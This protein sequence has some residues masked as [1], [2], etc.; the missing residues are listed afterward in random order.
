MAKRKRTRK[1]KIEKPN[2]LPVSFSR[3]NEDHARMVEL[4]SHYQKVCDEID[5]HIAAAS[6]LVSKIDPLQLLDRAYKENAAIAVG[7]AIEAELGEEDMIA[8]RMIDYVQCLIVSTPPNLENYCDLTN[9]HWEKLKTHVTAI[10]YQLVSYFIVASAKRETE[11]EVDIAWEILFTKAQMNWCYIKGDRYI[12]HFY[13]H[14]LSLFQPHDDVLEELFNISA[15]ELVNELEKI[16]VSLTEGMFDAIQELERMHQTFFDMLESELEQE[17][18]PETDEELGAFFRKKMADYGFKTKFDQELNRF[19]GL[20]LFDLEEVTNLPVKLLDNLSWIPGEEKTFLLK[21]QFKGWPLSLWPTWNKPFLKVNNK[22]YCFDMY[23]VSDNI[24]RAIQKII[25][26]LKPEYQTTWNDF[27]KEVSEEL[28]FQIFTKLLPEANFYRNVYYRW[29]TGENQKTN[30]IECDG[31][32]LYDDHLFII[33]VKA[34]AF[35]YTPPTTDAP[36]YIESIK[37]LLFTPAEQGQR[38]LEYLESS[39]NVLIYNEDH[40]PIGELSRK[41]FRHV[42]ICGI[43][44]DQITEL[45]AK[46]SHLQAI[47][48]GLPNTTNIWNVSIDDLR[49]YADILQNPLQFLHFIEQRHEAAKTR[50]IE[51]EDELDHLGL[52]L[53]HNRYAQHAEEFVISNNL[54]T[55]YT[56]IWSGYSSEINRYY[57]ELLSKRNAELPQQEIPTILEEIINQLSK[58]KT[59]GRAKVTSRLLDMSSETREQFST[60]AKTILDLARKK[61]RLQSFSFVGDDRVTIYCIPMLVDFEDTFDTEKHMLANLLI[62]NEPD[63]LLLELT[64]DGGDHLVN[65]QSSFWSEEDIDR[66]GREEIEKFANKLVS[67]RF[68]QAL[69]QGK[70]KNN[71]PCPCGSG[72]KYKDCHKLY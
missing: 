67:Q 4:A 71:E 47:E 33:E 24:Y 27:Q 25:Y 42:T 45:A 32:V 22:Y 21:G 59:P 48:G 5:N 40:K 52:Y 2:K 13:T 61:H 34:G 38:F 36:A 70:I 31:L 62:A 37:S 60:A 11:T 14:L 1:T 44:L 10:F 35:T 51:L 19:I 72:K 58:T 69:R 39:E 16:Q 30:W 17:F 18:I 54:K 41:S 28:P 26:R 7:K 9:E 49:V 63:R 23:A 53:E 20:G 15:T 6:E 68:S 56:I 55:P 3:G 50:L 12:N 29:K 8:R 43:T 66:Y 46:S 65:I 57:A 64:F